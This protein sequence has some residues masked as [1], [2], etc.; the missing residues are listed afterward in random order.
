[1]FTLFDGVGECFV[2]VKFV[3]P[4]VFGSHPQIAFIVKMEASD[5]D[6]FSCQVVGK[7]KI[8]CLLVEYI[9]LVLFT[10]KKT[11]VKIDTCDFPLQ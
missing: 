4:A 9:Y 1:M 5:R 10:D 11:F 7:V 6:I 3:Y 2:F 8:P